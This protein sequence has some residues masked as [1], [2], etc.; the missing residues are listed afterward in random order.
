M[1][2]WARLGL[3]VPLGVAILSRDMAAA[4]LLAGSEDA[5]LLA[6]GGDDQEVGGVEKV[7]QTAQLGLSAEDIASKVIS[8]KV[9]AHKPS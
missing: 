2:V 3:P 8:I 7:E 1:T 5:Q 9:K 4:E 6:M